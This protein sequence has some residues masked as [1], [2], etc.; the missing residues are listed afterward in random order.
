MSEIPDFALLLLPITGGLALAILSTRLSARLPIPAPGIFLLAAAIASDVW[1][2]LGEAVS[3]RTVERIAVVALIAILLN[4]GMDIGWTRMRRSVNPVVSL[5][6]LGTFLTAGLIALVAHV[7]LGFSWTLAGI[8]G[9]ALAPTD[10]AVMFSV[11]G[12]TEIRGR[13]G[14]ILEGEAG[15]NDPA[16]IALMLG[17]IEL[18]THTD[19]TLVTVV[20]EFGIEML[21]GLTAGFLGAQAL[22]PIVARVKLGSEELRPVLLIALAV[23]LYGVT[24]LLHGSG[25]L[26][27]FVAGLVFGDA[28]IP[29]KREVEEFNRSLAGVAEIVVF[30][31]LGL[32]I[33]LSGLPGSAWRDGAILTLA[34]VLVIRPLVVA[35]TLAQARLQ[36]GDRVFIAWS[37][38]KGAVPILLAA[39]ALLGG[40]DGAESVYG[41][42]FVA[43]LFSVFGQGSLV[44][45]VA[46]R[47][48]RT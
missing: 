48:S 27:V 1:T 36:P 4:G 11:L 24:S 13:A 23:V 46:R 3:I 8:V 21:V 16:G 6:V 31:A 41:L 10:P 17:M 38:L 44:P 39:F 2:Q 12:G 19:A 42:V 26:A 45:A 15:V 20:S 30:A 14:T 29:A 37:G 40:V 43:V 9:A 5:G 28:E 47:V 22:I 32:T 33:N 35:V 34:L 18:A 25:F 7:L